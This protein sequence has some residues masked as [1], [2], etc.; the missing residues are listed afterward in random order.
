M[1]NEAVGPTQSSL[2]I[3]SLYFLLTLLF[4]L[5]VRYDKIQVIF[6]YKNGILNVPLQIIHM[7]GKI[8]AL[9]II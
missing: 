7:Y 5:R 6:T 8:L 9:Q 1:G 4:L 2:L 3:Y